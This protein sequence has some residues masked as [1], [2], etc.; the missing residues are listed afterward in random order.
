MLFSQ[1]LE[2]AFELLGQNIQCLA[3]LSFLQSLTNTQDNREIDGQQRQGP[4]IY[5]LIG[6]AEVLAPL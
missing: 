3:S 6:F 5:T 4:A 2:T 1:T